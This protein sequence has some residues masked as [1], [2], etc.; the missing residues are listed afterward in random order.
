MAEAEAEAEAEANLI[1]GCRGSARFR[2]NLISVI[3]AGFRQT[4]EKRFFWLRP[5]LKRDLF[6]VECPWFR[7][8]FHETKL[9]V[10]FLSTLEETNAQLKNIEK[11]FNKS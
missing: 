6:S 4:L 8:Q 3:K 9:C 11:S 7:G 2:P 10:C 5:L 1:R